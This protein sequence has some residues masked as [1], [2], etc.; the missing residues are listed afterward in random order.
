MIVPCIRTPLASDTLL[1]RAG[2][3]CDFREKN[4]RCMVHTQDVGHQS[5]NAG[6]TGS[7]ENRSQ[8]IER[9]SHTLVLLQHG[10]CGMSDN[11]RRLTILLVDIPRHPG[12]GIRGSVDGN[13]G[14]VPAEVNVRQVTYRCSWQADSTHESH[15]PL[16]ERLRL[17]ELFLASVVIWSH[18]PYLQ[19]KT[20]RCI[21]QVSPP[22]AVEMNFLN[23]ATIA[24]HHVISADLHAKDC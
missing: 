21:H 22:N 18:G 10:D 1:H 16:L 8:Q 11:V 17:E 9:E 24:R 4:P 6:I 12:Q 13:N 5:R 23:H 7:F 14:E 20:L 3:P 2:S 15:P 19:A